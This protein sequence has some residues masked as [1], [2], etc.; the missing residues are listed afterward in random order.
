MKFIIIVRSYLI[1]VPLYARTNYF[2]DFRDGLEGDLETLLEK[3][4]T[5]SP[6]MIQHTFVSAIKKNNVECVR[7]MIENS[8]VNLDDKPYC[9]IAAKNSAFECLKYLHEN[10]C[11]F[12]KFTALICFIRDDTKSLNYVLQNGGQLNIPSEDQ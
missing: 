1:M 7:Y 4:D 11:S 5:Y 2:Q 3:K 8:L 10:G 6:D 9:D 12:R